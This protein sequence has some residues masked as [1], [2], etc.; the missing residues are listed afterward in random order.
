MTLKHFVRRFRGDYEFKTVAVALGGCAVSWAIACYNAVLAY[1]SASVWYATL[2]GYYGVL[3]LTRGA[4]LLSRYAG[5]KKGES[6]SRLRLRETNG[7]L[8]SGVLLVVLAFCFSGVTVLTVVRNYRYAYAGLTIY[9][10]ALYAFLKIGFGVYHLFKARR[11]DSDTVRALRNIG[12]ADALVSIAALQTA[13]L[14][15]FEDVSV[16]ATLFNGIT[17]VTAGLLVLCLGGY[18]IVRGC[19]ERTKIG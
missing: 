1:L 16:N 8:V 4:V 10:A 2:A 7:Y 18:M 15:V 17:G 11:R 5:R 12:F 19:R 9:V 13:M 3:S 14:G 6:G